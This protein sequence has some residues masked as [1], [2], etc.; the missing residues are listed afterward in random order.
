MQMYPIERKQLSTYWP[1]VARSWG[2]VDRD[3]SS[4]MPSMT[5][6]LMVVSRIAVVAYDAE[7]GDTTQYKAVVDSCPLGGADGT[8]AE[9]KGAYLWPLASWVD[10]CEGDDDSN[11]SRRVGCKVEPM[12]HRDGRTR[13]KSSRI[14]EAGAATEVVLSCSYS[15]KGHHGKRKRIGSSGPW[16]PAVDD[17]DDGRED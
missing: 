14:W 7:D 13:T 11:C 1:M 5:Q 3:S 17:D 12:V 15:G 9:R 8:G 6:L 16:V 2:T 4:S 10:D